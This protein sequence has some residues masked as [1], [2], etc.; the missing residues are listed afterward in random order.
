[1][2]PCTKNELNIHD[3]KCNK[4]QCDSFCSYRLAELRIEHDW[5]TRLQS[6]IGRIYWWHFWA[7]AGVL[8]FWQALLLQREEIKQVMKGQADAYVNQQKTNYAQAMQIQVM[9]QT[10]IL[11][12]KIAELNFVIE[13]M[14]INPDHRKNMDNAT[15]HV[16]ETINSTL[17]KLQDVHVPVEYRKVKADDNT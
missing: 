10:G 8:L 14:K 5:S 11:N 4:I 12:A 9:V 15:K 16:F 3:N 2:I 1:L 17:A 13:K 7:L 6:S